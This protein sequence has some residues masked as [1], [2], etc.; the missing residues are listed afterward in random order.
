[1]GTGCVTRDGDVGDEPCGG[2]GGW[3]GEVDGAAVRSSALSLG[4]VAGWIPRSNFHLLLYRL[5]TTYDVSITGQSRPN[6]F[7]SR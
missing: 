4:V 6:R 7:V 2:L 3:G 5:Y 1:M